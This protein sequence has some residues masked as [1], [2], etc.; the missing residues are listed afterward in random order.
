[1]LKIRFQLQEEPLRG[2]TRGKYSG[3]LQSVKLI[4]KEEGGTAFWKGIFFVEF[5]IIHIFLF[6]GHMP[7]QGLS[8]IY[9]VVQF[10]TFEELSHKMQELQ[11]LKN[12]TMSRDF[13][14]GALAGCTVGFVCLVLTIYIDLFLLS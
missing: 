2:K 9:G 5:K 1:M 12:H 4:W 7:A 3:I 13:L 6:I 14:C 11:W 10:T 8:A